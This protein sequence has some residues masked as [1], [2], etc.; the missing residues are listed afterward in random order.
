MQ[1]TPLGIETVFIY[2]AEKLAV[3]GVSECV[4]K[5]RGSGIT[6]PKTQFTAP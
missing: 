5:R 2:P 1:V 4:G 3:I 6:L